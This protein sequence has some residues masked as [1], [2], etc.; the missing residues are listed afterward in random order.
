GNI[1]ADDILWSAK[2]HPLRKA[3]A[4]TDSELHKIF[5]ETKNILHKA[6][7]LRGSS[8]GDYRDTAGEKGAYGNAILAYRR[9]GKPCKRC[10]TPICRTRTG[11]RS[12]HFCPKCQKL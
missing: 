10:K 9:T 8:V 7:R 6:I 12:A 3:N 2:V 1:Y 4:V 5:I 11:Q